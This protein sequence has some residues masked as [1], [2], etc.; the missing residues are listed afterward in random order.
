[1]DQ[2]P[3]VT[4]SSDPRR[5]HYSPGPRAH[6]LP[7]PS[8]KKLSVPDTLLYQAPERQTAGVS[9]LRMG[10]PTPGLVP[11]LQDPHR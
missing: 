7:R 1:M 11:F 6:Q 9:S 2:A 10:G 8:G 4:V 3:H 5:P